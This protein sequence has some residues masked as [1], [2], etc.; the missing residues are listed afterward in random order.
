MSDEQLLQALE[1]DDSYDIVRVLASHPSGTTELVSDDAG[2]LYVRKRIP[3]ELANREAWEALARVDGRRVPRVECIYELPDA[4]VVVCPYVMG[5]TV[6]QLLRRQA[7]LEAHEAAGIALGVCRAASELH[8]RGIVHRDISPGNVVVVPNI[9]GDSPSNR[10][11]LIDLGV[12]RVRTND[13]ASHDTTPLGTP[14]FSAPEQYGFA[15]TD[16]RSDVYSIGRLLACLLVGKASEEVSLDASA[17]PDDAVPPQLRGIIERACAFEP[18]ARYQSADQM[19]TDL[20]RAERE[21]GGGVDV[22]QQRPGGYHVSV[23]EAA[24]QG[25]DWR[26]E[27]RDAATRGAAGLWTRLGYGSS[28]SKASTLTCVLVVANWVTALMVGLAFIEAGFAGGSTR[29]GDALFYPVVGL[30]GFAGTVFAGHQIALCLLRGG[31]YRGVQRRGR[32]LLK[33]LAEDA[34]VTLALYMA[35]ALVAGAIGALLQG[36][37]AG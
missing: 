1:L 21:L 30:I 27:A 22:A 13:E 34:A 18:S 20:A 26:S 23:P 32:L 2:C 17:L 3:R 9:L 24:A 33:M 8:A 16:A 15:Q 10:T 25:Y 37:T 6:A 4:L 35:I 7:R 5:T 12:A 19:A 14:G 28:W 11:Y 29:P 31:R 36:V